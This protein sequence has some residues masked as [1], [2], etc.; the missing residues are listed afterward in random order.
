[1]QGE[2]VE[3]R[4]AEKGIVCLLI[5]ANGLLIG[6]SASPTEAGLVECYNWL[7]FLSVAV[8]RKRFRCYSSSR[9]WLACHGIA[10]IP[11]RSRKAQTAIF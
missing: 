10:L 7:F 4:G 3:G 11:P 5:L 6:R 2:R 1:M 9:S 8:L